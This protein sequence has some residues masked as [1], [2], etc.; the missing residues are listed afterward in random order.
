[1]FGERLGRGEKVDAILANTITV[2]EGYPTARSA[3]Q[4]GRKFNIE[5]PIIDEV[6]AMLY[7]GKKL[8]PA[9]KDLMGRDSKAE[10]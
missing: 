8:A 4:L 9:L 10:N 3:R 5:T 1:M 2:A 7:E 6:Y